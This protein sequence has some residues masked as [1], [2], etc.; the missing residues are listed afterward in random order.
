MG[1]VTGTRGQGP[2]TTAI[3]AGERRP[4]AAALTTPIYETSTFVFDSVAD[5]IK[6]QEGSFDGYLYSRYENPTVISVEQKIAAVDQ[7]ET[8]LLFSSGMA[9]IAT[10]LL[11][12]LNDVLDFSKSDTGE[13]QFRVGKRLGDKTTVIYS[14]SFAEGGQRKLRVEY[15]VLGPLLLAGEQAFDGGYGGDVIVRLRFR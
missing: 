9:A 8:S 12:L 14:G 11:T 4:A 15:Q 7:A 5:V 13:S 6:Y 3:H 1:T 10:A 2:A